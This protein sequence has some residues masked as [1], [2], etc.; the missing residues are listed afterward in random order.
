LI[1]RA[2]RCALV[3]LVVT[4]LALKSGKESDTL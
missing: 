1:S 3:R 4:M 2:Q